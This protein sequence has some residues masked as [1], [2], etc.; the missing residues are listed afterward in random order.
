LMSIL[1]T[2][3]NGSVINHASYTPRLR[4]TITHAPTAG[5]T[6]KG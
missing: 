4:F 3:L 6:R 2:P 5:I 1:T